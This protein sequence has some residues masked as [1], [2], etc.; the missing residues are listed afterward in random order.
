[1][2]KLVLL[3]FKGRKRELRISIIMLVLIYMCGI[4]TIL[5]QESFYRSRENLR[6][7]TYGEW[8]GAVFGAGEGTGQILKE[9]ESTKR[10]GKMVMKGSFWQDGKRIGEAG[11]VDH[12]AA[13]L[14][15]IQTA[16]GHLPSDGTEIA[17]TETV[18]GRLKEKVKIGDKIELALSENGEMESYTLSGI[19]KPWG[20]EWTTEKHELPSVILGTDGTVQGETYLFFKSDSTDELNHIQARLETLGEG[21]YVYNE[22]AYPLDISVLD[23]FFLEGKYIFFIVL[24]AAILICYLMMLTLK[25]RR[26]SLTVLRGIGADAAEVI[27]LVLWETA[28]LW[29][30]AFL[31]GVVMSAIMTGV[32]LYMVHIIVKIPVHFTIPAEFILEYITCVT[33]IYFMCNLAGALTVIWSQIR[34]TFKYDSGLLEGGALPK[35]TKAEK[36]TFFTCLKRKW[37]FYNKVHISR[38]AVSTI[39]MVLTAVCLQL[40]IEAKDKYEFWMGAVEYAYGY[41]ADSLAEG[42]TEEQIVEL[43]R[44]DGVKSVEKDV[45]I[46]SNTMTQD[47]EGVQE[48]KISASAFKDSEYVN[49][50]RR[51][52]QKQRQIPVDEEGDY[53][54]VLELR[55]LGPQ[56]EERLACYERASDMGTLDRERFISGEECVLILP[57]YQIR[58][59]GG[60]KEPVYVNTVEMDESRDVYTYEADENAIAPG[61]MVKI[62]TPWGEREVQVGAVITNPEADLSVDTQVAAV[63]ER[64]VNLL[65]GLEEERYTAVKMNLDETADTAGTGAEIEAYFEAL[66]KGANLRNHK[67]AVRSFAEDSIFDETQYLFILTTVWLVYMLVM[68][69]GNQAYLKNEGKRIGVLRAIGMDRIMLKLRYMLEN[70]FEGGAVILLSIVIVTGNFL[71]RLKKNAP[72]DSINILVQSLAD[73]PEDVRL[74]LMALLIAVTVFLGVSIVTLYMPLKKLSGRSIVEN[75][76]DGERR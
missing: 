12:T 33:V 13:A 17:V 8:M 26:Y 53:F 35:L 22:K 47:M 30:A 28:F 31:A 57:P 10:I 16:E 7:D 63:S 29:G 65:C 9:M 76:D 42:L 43:E 11:F 60:G 67:S 70:I 41:E 20:R 25:S 24:I 55:G 18:A 40:F 56:D 52:E 6:R 45:F 23:E 3:S 37:M 71:I 61:D 69:H 64:F 75:L 58:D 51:Y 27:Q 73:N 14:G 54:S 72:Y 21:T 39:V 34:T 49:T 32:V 19:V 38:F 74:F 68:Y 1:M 66:G 44:I 2:R 15:R 4:M 36:I 50:H 48:I 62:S 46:N 5:F 59:L